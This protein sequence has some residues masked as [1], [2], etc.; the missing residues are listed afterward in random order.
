MQH[1]QRPTAKN[2]KLTF[3]VRRAEYHQPSPLLPGTD[4]PE[5]CA[6]V[7]C[8][9]S[10]LDAARTKRAHSQPLLYPLATPTLHPFNPDCS[11]SQVAAG[12]FAALDA[13]HINMLSRLPDC[14]VLLGWVRSNFGWVGCFGLVEGG[15]RIR[16]AHTGSWSA[17]AVRTR[18]TVVRYSRKSR[19]ISK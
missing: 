7:D 17:A 5:L 6:R 16:C 14:S 4:T 2:A 12:D 3:G 13:W 9:S 11:R 8:E 18:C 15:C 1:K 19:N 10:I